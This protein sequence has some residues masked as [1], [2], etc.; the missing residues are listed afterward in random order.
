LATIQPDL[1]GPDANKHWFETYRQL[2]EGD[3]VYRVP[4]TALFILTRY[5]DIAMVVRDSKRFSNEPDKHG[6]ESLL[7]HPEARDIYDRR[8]WPKAFPLSQDPPEHKRFRALVNHFFTGTRLE[9][10][11]ALITQHVNRLIDVFAGEGGIEFI[12][13]FAEPLP[14][15]VISGLLGLPAEDHERLKQWSFAW[16][17]PFAR[18]LSL[19]QEIWVAEQGVAFQHYLKSHIDA[20]RAHPTDDIISELAH[21]RL[22]DRP[23]SDGEIV[24]IID[25]LYIGGN[26]TTAFALASG[27]WMMLR[28]SDV[29][30]AL[31]AN[32]A[33]IKGFVEEVLRLESPTQGLYRTAT[34]ETEIRGVHIPKGATLH[35]RFAAANRDP[36]VFEDPDTIQLNRPNAMRHMAFSQAEHHCP[37]SGLS[38]LELQIAFET[39]I[40]RL[41]NLRLADRGNDFEHHPGFVLRALKALHIAFDPVAPQS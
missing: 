4:G 12:T 32:P 28:D 35:L 6:G 20:R 24:Q 31:A 8:G 15:V 7:L 11:R 30:A 41:P 22:D 36:D 27:L 5:D 29:L 37:G 26:E 3:P 23:L 33:L 25:H 13:A 14:A 9:Q 40:A 10:S 34:R 1:F 2:R 21:A 18:G 38:R 39:L 16:A 17:L 19:E